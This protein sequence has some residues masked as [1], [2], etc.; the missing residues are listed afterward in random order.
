VA[1]LVLTAYP[2]KGLSI[3]IMN[4]A[5][6]KQYLDNTSDP[7]RMMLP[8]YYTNVNISYILPIKRPVITLK[9][10]LNNIFNVLYVNSGST[11][12]ARYATTDA[13]G[14]L[15]VSPVI[16]SNYYFPQAGFNL[17]GG[18]TVRF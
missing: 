14:N 6:S 1:S 11:Y 5:V 4:K 9:L 16:A 3:S 10:L 2:I 17:L 15:Q 18:V 13:N 12:P 8:F 7:N